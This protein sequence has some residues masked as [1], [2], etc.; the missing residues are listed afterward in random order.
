MKRK[1]SVMA[2]SLTILLD[3]NV[4]IAV[5]V[6]LRKLRPSWIVLHTSEV[7][8]G[9]KSDKEI[10]EW[11]QIRRAVIITFD[12]D[13]ADRRLFQ[14]QDHPGVVRLRVWPTTIEK[15]QE[16]LERLLDEVTEEELSGA[17]VIID[18][19]RIRIRPAKIET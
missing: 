12:E 7:G 14:S 18:R 17:L 16:A 15:T 2:D 10:F 4:P 11:A 6:W 5:A 19:T 1:S 9:A 13:F 8:L 3:Q